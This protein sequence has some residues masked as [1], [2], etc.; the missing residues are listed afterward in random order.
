MN[1]KDMTE[2]QLEDYVDELFKQ[3][4]ADFGNPEPSEKLHILLCFIDDK[5]AK[6]ATKTSP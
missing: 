5:K 3:V 1:L 6:C 2:S 4:C